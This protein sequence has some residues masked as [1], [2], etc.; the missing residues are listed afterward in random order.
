MDLGMWQEAIEDFTLS[1]S[2]NPI[3]LLAEFSIGDCYMRLSEYELAM[4]QFK[5]SLLIDPLHQP[6]NDFLK[7]AID[8]LGK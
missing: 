4:E 5:K 7:A 6:S 8:R 2:V 3:S 1:L